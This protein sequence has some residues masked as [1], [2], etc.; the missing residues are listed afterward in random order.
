MLYLYYHCSTSYSSPIEPSIGNHYSLID[1]DNIEEYDWDTRIETASDS[2]E[3][4]EDEWEDHVERKGGT[5][6]WY[7]YDPSNLIH[8]KHKGYESQRPEHVEWLALEVNRLSVAHW[9]ERKVRLESLKEQKEQ[10]TMEIN[11]LTLGIEQ[12]EMDSSIR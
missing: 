6:L 9:A 3:E 2:Y 5:S 1:T 12:H 7:E 8:I 4:E 10:I 11:Y